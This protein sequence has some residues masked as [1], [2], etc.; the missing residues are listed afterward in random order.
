MPTAFSA[1]RPRP[2]GGLARFR[3]KRKDEVRRRRS[4]AHRIRHA[5]RNCRVVPSRVDQERRRP[6]QGRLHLAPTPISE[7]SSSPPAT[8]GIPRP[9]PRVRAVLQPRHRRNPLCRAESPI[10]RSDRLEL[11]RELASWINSP[12]TGSGQARGTGASPTASQPHPPFPTK[13]TPPR[14]RATQNARGRPPHGA[15]SP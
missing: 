9:P 2:Q 11:G 3:Q 1:E 10:R 13:K 12:S 8:P 5:Q 14:A 6:D 4:G 7:S 15:H